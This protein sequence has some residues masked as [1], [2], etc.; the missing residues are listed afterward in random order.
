M[1]ERESWNVINFPDT[2][3]R[4]N[5][6]KEHAAMSHRYSPVTM[7]IS[8][9]STI[10]QIG[11]IPMYKKQPNQHVTE[12]SNRNRTGSYISASSQW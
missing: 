12:D 3:P 11:S 10:T 1:L 6:E 2:I 4:R 9:L 8:V 7:A 5:S